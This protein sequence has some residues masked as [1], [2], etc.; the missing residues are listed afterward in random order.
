VLI[1]ATSV[2]A[3]FGDSEGVP[4]LL[5]E[6]TQ[7]DRAEWH[8]L[9]DKR[10][11][12]LETKDTRNFKAIEERLS[13]LETHVEQR[14][15]AL[16]ANAEQPLSA[17]NAGVVVSSPNPEV[18]GGE[19]DSWGVEKF[20]NAHEAIQAH[21]QG[22]WEAAD[23]SHLNYVER[24][25][26]ACLRE[27]DANT[28]LDCIKKGI[29]GKIGKARQEYRHLTLGSM[30]AFYSCDARGREKELFNDEWVLNNGDA[31]SFNFSAIPTL[32]RN[33]VL[34]IFGESTAEQLLDSLLKG[35]AQEGIHPRA[36][37]QGNPTHTRKWSLTVGKEDWTAQERNED[38]YFAKFNFTVRFALGYN[39]DVPEALMM[40]LNNQWNEG[41]EADAA[42]ILIGSHYNLSPGEKF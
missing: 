32:M 29:A 24:E 21:Q 15:R 39:Y 41:G 12:Q 17:T 10:V 35:L 8:K 14:L 3:T 34:L 26:L 5:V 28:L 38:W 40:N 23:L 1:L 11:T 22:S 13:E 25:Q 16:E 20:S 42:I 27:S 2:R 37:A 6:T 18:H 31:S 7:V 9:L 4:N 36:T 30:L 19:S 33:K